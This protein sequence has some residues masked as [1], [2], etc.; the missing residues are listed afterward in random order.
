M[1]VFGLLRGGRCASL[2]WR[3]GEG[4]EGQTKLPINRH[5]R[6]A[7]QQFG[8]FYDHKTTIAD[9]VAKYWRTW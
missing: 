3:G 6:D 9:G 4:S 8:K 7:S 2:F 5:A 1:R